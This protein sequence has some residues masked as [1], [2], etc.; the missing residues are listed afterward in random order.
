MVVGYH[1][2]KAVACNVYVYDR[3][4][5][6][7]QKMHIGTTYL[8]SSGY[9]LEQSQLHGCGTVCQIAQRPF[10]HFKSQ[11]DVRVQGLRRFHKSF[12]QRFLRLKHLHLQTIHQ[13]SSS[14]TKHA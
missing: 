4:L 11:D 8:R 5:P 9:E 10:L 3:S 2:S 14:P 1:I 7:A 6:V 13:K 12:Q